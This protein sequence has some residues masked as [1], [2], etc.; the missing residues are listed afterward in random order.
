[1]NIDAIIQQINDYYEYRRVKRD[2]RQPSTGAFAPYERSGVVKLRYCIETGDKDACVSID[3]KTDYLKIS[4]EVDDNGGNPPAGFIDYISV[5]TY[6][7]GGNNS[8]SKFYLTDEYEEQIVASYSLENNGN[9]LFIA[10]NVAYMYSV[11]TDTVIGVNSPN[12]IINNPIFSR[13]EEGDL[14]AIGTYAGN[15]LTIPRL[16][17]NSIFKAYIG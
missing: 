4:Q 13:N 9:L 1:M 3:D 11:S 16:V 12:G 10:D 14:L 2:G 6:L 17:Q 7:D 5:S 15:E 8:T